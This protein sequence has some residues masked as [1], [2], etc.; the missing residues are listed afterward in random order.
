MVSVYVNKEN[1]DC[2]YDEMCHPVTKINVD[3][4]CS[5]KPGIIWKHDSL[6]LRPEGRAPFVKCTIELGFYA[7]VSSY[8]RISEQV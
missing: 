3:P 6:A 7:S 2:V 4:V 8:Q 1:F 5:R